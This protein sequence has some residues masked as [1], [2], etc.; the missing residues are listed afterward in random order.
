MN[1]VL[2]RVHQ[3]GD[4]TIGKLYDSTSFGDKFICY[5]LE[6]KVRQ[7][8]NQPV[9]QWKVQNQTAIPRGTYPVTITLSNRFKVNLP[10]LGN[11]PG[12]T[13]IRIHSGNSSKD[14]EGCILVGSSWDGKSNWIGTSKL[15]LGQLMD[16]LDGQT[17]VTIKVE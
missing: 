17:N 2:K 15:A 4:F 10:L 6:D 11:V 3:G 9:E 7:V 13:G 5:T 12:F 8:E 16:L 14:T 1:L